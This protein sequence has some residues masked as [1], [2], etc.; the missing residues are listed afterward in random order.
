[1]LMRSTFTGIRT[2]KSRNYLCDAAFVLWPPPKLQQRH[3]PTPVFRSVTRGSVLTK[4]ATSFMCLTFL[5]VDIP[6]F[7]SPSQQTLFNFVETIRVGQDLKSTGHPVWQ[8]L[9]PGNTIPLGDFER[10]VKKIGRRCTP[11]PH[12]YFIICTTSDIAI[13]PL[14]AE[15]PM[16]VIQPVGGIVGNGS[17]AGFKGDIELPPWLIGQ[18]STS[19]KDSEVNV[20]SD[21]SD[22]EQSN[23]TENATLGAPSSD[24]ASTVNNSA[25]QNSGEEKAPSEV[26]SAA[27]AASAQAQAL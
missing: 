14:V 19:D 5:I 11:I 9:C 10:P 26:S 20:P 21:G 2:R 4:S 27:Q 22:A 24:A 25:P 7:A 17:D 13:I 15:P 16:S 23:A 8:K 12:S 1:M 6:S 18:I 3:F